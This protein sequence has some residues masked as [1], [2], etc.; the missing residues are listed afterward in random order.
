ML[1]GLSPNKKFCAKSKGNG[2]LCEGS[3]LSMV[4]DLHKNISSLPGN[5]IT[6]CVNTPYANNKNYSTSLSLVD[7]IIILQ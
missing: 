5:K 2:P 6:L 4:L 7:S 3:V 1:W